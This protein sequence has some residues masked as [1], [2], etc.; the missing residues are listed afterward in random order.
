MSLP[1][2]GMEPAEDCVV[3]TVMHETNWPEVLRPGS[4]YTKNNCFTI[5]HLAEGKRRF[6]G[7]KEVGCFK[8]VC[9]RLRAFTKRFV[10]EPGTQS[11][12]H[13]A[14]RELCACFSFFVLC[15]CMRITYEMCL[16]SGCSSCLD[17]LIT[18]LLFIDIEGGTSR[19]NKYILPSF[20]PKFWRFLVL[21]FIHTCWLTAGVVCRL[22][23][24]PL[25]EE[26]SSVH[27]LCYS[28][29]AQRSAKMSF[30]RANDDQHPFRNC[31]GC[32]RESLLSS[33]L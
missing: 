33:A 10:R 6:P 23:C 22:G 11:M 18:V 1:F 9:S 13:N 4:I 15:A 20:F 21:N 24:K 2:K 17:R 32:T 16:Y 26:Q 5:H 28:I 3:V 31:V 29:I 30:F 19:R 27:V 7:V 25:E 14:R 8:F 12:L